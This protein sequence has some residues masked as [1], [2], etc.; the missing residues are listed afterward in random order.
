MG[1]PEGVVF[2]SISPSGD[3][4]RFLR[5]RL[6]EDKCLDRNRDDREAD[7]YCKGGPLENPENVVCTREIITRGP[8]LDY[9]LAYVNF[10]KSV[11]VF[12]NIRAILRESTM[13]LRRRML[14]LLHDGA[15]L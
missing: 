3:I 4:I 15:G 6:G 11:L 7:M 12:L 8:A 9:V 13:D 5:T 14:S 1:L 10:S 2:T